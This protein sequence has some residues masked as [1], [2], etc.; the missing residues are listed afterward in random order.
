MNALPTP[1][2]AGDF[3]ARHSRSFRFAAL[4]LGPEMRGRVERVYAWCRHTDNIVDGVVVG[5]ETPANAVDQELDA[6]LSAS[7]RAFEGE[8]TGVELLDLVMGDLRTSGGSFDV[9]EALVRGVRSDLHFQPFADFSALRVYTHDVAAVVGRWLCALNDI[10]DP[11]LLHR[12]EALGHAMQ[13]TNILRDVGEDLDVGRVYLPLD[14]LAS[15]HVSVLDLHRMRSGELPILPNYRG[16]IEHLIAKAEADYALAW[17][18]IPHLPREFGRCVGVAA[19][20]YAGIHDQIRANGYDNFS[21]RAHTSLGRKLW[22]A[23]GALRSADSARPL[24]SALGVRS[25]L[26]AGLL[27]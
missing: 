5:P 1:V 9:V 27:G 17:E 26:S 21:K 13:L 6:W 3:M 10:R 22:L 16:V 11:W 2:A 20:V 19:R 7:R 12:A 8:H 15:R 25:R 14:V 18:A 24:L 23:A 4:T